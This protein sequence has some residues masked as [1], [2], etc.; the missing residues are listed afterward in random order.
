MEPGIANR[1]S[2]Q[3]DVPPLSEPENCTWA[4]SQG[5]VCTCNPEATRHIPIVGKMPRI[6]SR[7]LYCYSKTTI[8]FACRH[9][10]HIVG[11]L[12]KPMETGSYGTTVHPHSAKVPVVDA[13]RG[14]VVFF[15]HRKL[16]K[17]VSVQQWRTGAH[18]KTPITEDWKG[19]MFKLMPFQLLSCDNNLW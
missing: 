1:L 10:L 11:G 13:Y 7:H 8:R 17:L 14:C 5:P 16:K 2:G 15:W 4:V 3:L 9:K 19:P 6:I 12:N 18:M